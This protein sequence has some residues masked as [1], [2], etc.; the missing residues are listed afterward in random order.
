M[1][2]TLE[3]VLAAPPV[4]WIEMRAALD[5][6]ATAIEYARALASKR[7]DADSLDET[8]VLRRRLR[9]TEHK[10]FGNSRVYVL[11]RPDRRLVKIGVTTNLAE[12]MR[13]LRTAA[14]CELSLLLAFAGARG[15]EQL[16]HARF[17]HLRTHGEWFRYAPSLE[18]WVQEKR[19]GG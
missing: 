18:R 5:R 10:V 7:A 3:E 11:K 4:P 2:D 9:S 17:A 6:A 1:A 8:N 19:A 14:G 12:R 16:L 15:D 13:T